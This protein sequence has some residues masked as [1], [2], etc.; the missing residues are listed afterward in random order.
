MGGIPPPSK[1]IVGNLIQSWA[2]Q[3]CEPRAQAFEP[4]REQSSNDCKAPL[5]KHSKASREPI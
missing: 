4:I 3:S 1:V 2:G 5:E